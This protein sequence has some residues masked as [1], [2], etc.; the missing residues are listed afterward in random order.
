M[1]NTKRF[2][3]NDDNDC[4]LDCSFTDTLTNKIYYID[5]WNRIINL[6]NNLSQQVQKLEKENEEL[7][8]IIKGC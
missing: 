2:V 6:C 3:N 5:E 7:K 4:L 8:K 1:D